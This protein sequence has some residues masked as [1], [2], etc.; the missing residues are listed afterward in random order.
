MFQKLRSFF[1]K[2]RAIVERGIKLLRI[3]DLFGTRSIDVARFTDYADYLSKVS[4]K[5]WATFKACDI[6]GKVLMDTPYRFTRAGGSG[7]AVEGS[8]VGKLLANPNEFFTL[9]EMIYLFAFHIK[10]TGNAYWAKDEPNLNGDRPRRLIPLNPKRVKPVLD[11]KKGLIGY[12]HRINGL[13]IPYDANEILHFRNPHPDNDYYGIGDI[14]PGQ[15]LFKEFLNRDAYGE[16]FWKNGA[17]P[18]GIL[19][20][21]DFGN[22]PVAW[23]LA[24]QK[25]QREYG[26]PGNA[27]KTAWLTGKWTYTQ[28]GLSAK[29]MEQIEASKFTLENIFHLH[30][31]PLSVAGIRDAA[32]FATAR[33]DDLIFRRY[34]I[35]PMIKILRDTLQIDLVAGYNGNLILNFDVSGLTDLDSVVTNLVPLFDRGVLSVNEL[36]VAAGYALSDDPLFDQHFINAGLVP[37]EL[38]GI[39][40]QAQTEQQA[41]A[42]VTRF[43]LGGKA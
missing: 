37:F 26:G 3:E 42:T 29:E 31:V 36:R 21:E 20:S 38:A 5:V 4:T 11:Q 30:G 35:K 18:A 25:W 19:I 15:S 43:L 1:T 14:E 39:A 17:S 34:T 6:I 32:N 28:L 33:V 40:N 13:D 10:A 27:N 7:Q 41:Q 12:V 24:K 2:S 22:D 23:E 8:E 16:A 9:S